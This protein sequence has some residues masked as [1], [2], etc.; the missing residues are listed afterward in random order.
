[1]RQMK[2]GMTISILAMLLV[3]A[4]CCIPC[5]QWKSKYEACESEKANLESLLASSQETLDQCNADR[6]QM[7]G[8]LGQSQMDLQEAMKKG[9]FDPG[10]A[11]E[12][13][14]WDPAKGTIT[15]TLAT[16]VFFDS[17]KVT[18]KS[19][20][21]AR[22]KR[23]AQVIQEKYAG[24][25]ISIVGH[26]DT[27]P[28]KKS[29]WQ[30]NWQLSAERALAVTRYMIGQKIP[31]KRLAAAG[32]SQYHPVSKQKTQNRRVEIIVHLFQ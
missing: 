10:F 5:L 4:G 8:Q 24:K 19:N 1:M 2:K 18:L 30:D 17:G 3:S 29:K 16:D 14:S 6:D 21:K 25:E 32:R 26:T 12:E 20:A 9:S 11:G 7:A 13:T 28:I 15:V 31:P 27:D 22:L 23:I